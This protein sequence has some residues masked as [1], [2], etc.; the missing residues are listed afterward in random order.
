MQ[1]SDKALVLDVRPYGDRDYLIVLL[2]ETQ[3]R[4]SGLL[5]CGGRARSMANL[6]D[7]V[8]VQWFSRLE[9]HL[10]RFV[11]QLI[12]GRAGHVLDTHDRLLALSS[13][14]TALMVAVPERLHIPYLFQLTDTYL[15]ILT[16]VSYSWQ[17]EH[18]R[19]E[20]NSLKILGYGL[21]LESCAVTG[22]VAPLEYVSPKTGHAVTK[23]GAG[24]YADKLL[25]L[26][27]FLIKSSNSP[28]SKNQLQLGWELVNYFWVKHFFSESQMGKVFIR[29]SLGVY[30]NA[31]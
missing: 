26:P 21:S 27:E 24:P 17:K 18:I 4:R 13:V 31:S 8:H 14:C 19:W 20:L 23:A 11:I 6:G 25:P 12:Q 5:K 30:F 28:I 7:K 15:D 29:Q 22:A 16:D 3:G 10:G 2:T 9:S 1:W